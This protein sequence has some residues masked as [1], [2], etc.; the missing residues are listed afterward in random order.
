LAVEERACSRHSFDGQCAF[1]PNAVR[2]LSFQ[3]VYPIR[4]YIQSG[5]SDVALSSLRRTQA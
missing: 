4:P 5:G 2:F 3:Q 1:F